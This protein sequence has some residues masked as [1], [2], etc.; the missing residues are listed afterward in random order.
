MLS[1]DHILIYTTYAE[2]VSIPV[3]GQWVLI[4]GKMTIRKQKR[5]TD[6]SDMMAGHFVARYQQIRWTSCFHGVTSQKTVTFTG[7][8]MITSN[9]SHRNTLYS[10]TFSTI[11]VM[12]LWSLRRWV[13]MV[14]IS[15]LWS[16]NWTFGWVIHCKV[17][18]M[19]K[20]F[21]LQS[22]TGIVGWGRLLRH[23]AWMDTVHKISHTLKVFPLHNYCQL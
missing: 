15:I 2:C 19:F 18:R 3:L 11:D 12:T 23:Q 20:G 14:A 7:A 8:A 17:Q 13:P 16:I 22:R 5:I 21:I 9:L 1:K 10:L 4:P 6:F